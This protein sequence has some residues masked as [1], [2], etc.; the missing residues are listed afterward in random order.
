MEGVSRI[1]GGLRVCSCAGVRKAAFREPPASSH[2]LGI[3]FWQALYCRHSSL[4]KLFKYVRSWSNRKDC[5]VLGRQSFPCGPAGLRHENGGGRT[6]ACRDCSKCLDP[7]S[8]SKFIQWNRHEI[9]SDCETSQTCQNVPSASHKMWC[10]TRKTTFLPHFFIFLKHKPTLKG[11]HQTYIGGAWVNST[12]SGA[13][14]EP[15]SPCSDSVLVVV[16]GCLFAQMRL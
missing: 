7:G 3:L 8:P 5:R 9:A 4:P 12:D 14:T 6:K 2:C 11:I 16:F 13:Q 15:D 1:I 10:Q